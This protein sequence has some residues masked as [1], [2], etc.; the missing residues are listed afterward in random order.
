MSMFDARKRE[1]ACRDDRSRKA[2]ID[3]A[4]RPLVD[5]L[6]AKRNFYTTSSCAGRIVLLERPS[7][8]KYD[9]RWMLVSHHNVTSG[10]VKEVLQP[11]E[12]PVWLKAESPILHLC[13]RTIDDAQVF[14][15]LAKESGF[16]RTG[17][18]SAKNRIIIECMGT[19][20]IDTIVAKESRILVSDGYLQVLAHEANITLSR[21][22][23]RLES[24]RDACE[25]RL[26]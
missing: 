23:E 16:K 14:L 1:I 12:A 8:N 10:Q 17:I 25:N 5:C 7:D 4:V 24:L 22:W 15:S 20:R 26:S 2:S 9:A 11:G 19:D 21:N 18:I 6:N 13:A 3:S